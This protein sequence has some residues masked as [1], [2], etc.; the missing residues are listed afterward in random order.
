MLRNRRED[1]YQIINMLG[2]QPGIKVIRIYNKR[3]EITFSTIPDEVGKVIP[4]E[5]EACNVCHK[6]G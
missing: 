6:N 2:K 1:I 4:M 3:G 5:S